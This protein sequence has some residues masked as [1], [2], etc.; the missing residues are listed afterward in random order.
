MLHHLSNE[1]CAELIRF[2]LFTYLFKQNT[3]KNLLYVISGLLIVIW[4]IIF[5]GFNSSGSVH[6]LLAFAGLA[7]L[8]GF[9]L[10]RRLTN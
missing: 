9:I 1:P 5:F 6:W 7:I 4:G 8:M 2:G 10:T 3:M